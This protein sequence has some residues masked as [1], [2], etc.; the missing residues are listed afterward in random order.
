MV[1]TFA[2]QLKDI[3]ELLTKEMQFVASE[4]V[5]DVMEGA[6][7]PQQGITAG[8]S[9]FVEGKIPVAE[10][11]LINSLEV[12][13]ASGK[14]AYVVAI[15]GMEIGGVQ[16]FTWNAPHAMPMEVG[17]T[18]ENGTQVPGRF[19][20]SRNAERFSEFVEKNVKRLRR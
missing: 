19:F 2:A 10:A 16:R 15:A 13:G 4:S 6:Q 9:G 5:Q 11:E 8:G 12:D 14:D 7:T 17:F 18:A 20:V 1:K 3:E